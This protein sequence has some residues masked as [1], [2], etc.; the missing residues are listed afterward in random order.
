M[1]KEIG[2]LNEYTTGNKKEAAVIHDTFDH[3]ENVPSRSGESSFF[4][5][6]DSKIQDE[7]EEKELEIDDNCSDQEIG[8]DKRTGFID[9]F[10]DNISVADIS[11]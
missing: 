4:G 9:T 11:P 2:E 3:R 7:D 8:G 5:K 6:E 1:L 10:K